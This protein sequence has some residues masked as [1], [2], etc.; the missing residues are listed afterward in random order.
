[1]SL[2]S[3]DLRQNQSLMA[4]VTAAIT[5]Y[6]EQEGQT[7]AAPIVPEVTVKPVQVPEPGFWR[8]FRYM[9]FKR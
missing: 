4:A 7:L 8:I 1:M 6:L 2:A 9:I 3:L 5:A